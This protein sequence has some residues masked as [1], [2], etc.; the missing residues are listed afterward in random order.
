[1]LATLHHLLL[2]AAL[3]GLDAGK[4]FCAPGW[5]VWADPE[6]GGAAKP[7]VVMYKA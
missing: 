7:S 3:D 5:K 2:Q 1:M 6:E 4:R